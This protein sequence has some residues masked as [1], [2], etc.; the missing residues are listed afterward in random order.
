MDGIIYKL[1]AKY[2]KVI[3]VPIPT[4]LDAKG[5][6]AQSTDF[7][8]RRLSIGEW[9]DRVFQFNLD[10]VLDQL[11]EPKEYDVK[12]EDKIFSYKP[13]SLFPSAF[14][15]IAVWV[16]ENKTSEDIL[17]IITRLGIDFNIDGHRG[18]IIIEKTA[19]TN[20]ALE[21]HLEATA[22]DVI[23]AAEMALPHRMRKQPFEEESFSVEVLRRL[24]RKYQDE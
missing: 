9:M 5:K 13:F 22:D 3:R 6:V 11:P 20:A 21:G 7:Y 12:S 10:E 17:S 1:K 19:R 18:D 8:F 2:G 24:V 14:R 23:V 15:D 16:P 4:K